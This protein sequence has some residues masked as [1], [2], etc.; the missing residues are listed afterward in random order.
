[1][2]FNYKYRGQDRVCL[3][4]LGDGAVNQGQVYES[5]NMAALWKLPVI[6]CIENN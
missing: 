4:Y 2:A 3:T 6:Y 1:M 5:F